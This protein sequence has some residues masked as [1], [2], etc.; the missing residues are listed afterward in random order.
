M[1]G[2]GMAAF[3]Q[4]RQV[5]TSA[6]EN[7]EPPV[8]WSAFEASTG[9]RLPADYRAYADTYG[10]TFINEL[11]RIKHPTSERYGCNLLNPPEQWESEED[12]ERYLETHL[13]TPP[14]PLGVGR[15][16][17]MLCAD[18]GPDQI[19]WDTSGDDP[20]TW[21]V[22]LGDEDGDSWKPLDMTLVEF[23]LALFTGRMPEL[24]FERAGYVTD[25]ILIESKPGA[26]G[27]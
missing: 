6:D 5:V 2:D 27:T 12:E 17:L 25:E 26:G 3:E 11:Y 22:V 15:N 9:L 20:D 14:L 10:P 13:S 7:T 24:G 23:L 8:D 19:Y 4:W 1:P 18:S 16:R 21:T